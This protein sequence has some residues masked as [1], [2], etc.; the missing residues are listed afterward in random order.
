MV[1][2]PRWMELDERAIARGRELYRASL[3]E[4]VSA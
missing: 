2:N 3:K 1:K 4:M